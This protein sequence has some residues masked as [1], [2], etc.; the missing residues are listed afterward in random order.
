MVNQVLSDFGFCSPRQFFERVRVA[1]AL[2][3]AVSI[4][5]LDFRHPSLL[6]LSN[7]ELG[8]FGN[9][10]LILLSFSYEVSSL[11]LDPSLKWMT[12]PNSHGTLLWNDCYYLFLIVSYL[13][14][15]DFDL[16]FL[17]VFFTHACRPFFWPDAYHWMEVSDLPNKWLR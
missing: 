5:I 13:C 6:S 10:I 1:C 17:H 16:F 15:S 9:T 2:S 4:F 14:Y 8:N 12:I 11:C 7:K 3:Y